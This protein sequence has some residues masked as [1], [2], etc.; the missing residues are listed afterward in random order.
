[1][2]KKKI[3][4]KKVQL[5]MVGIILFIVSV[6][7]SLCIGF[8]AELSAFSKNGI[9]DKNCPDAYL[10]STGTTDIKDFTSDEKVDIKDVYVL[11]GKTLSVPIQWKDKDISMYYDMM[12]DGSELEAWKYMSTT[13]GQAPNE[14]EIIISETLAIP[15]NINIGDTITV[16]YENPISFKVVGFYHTT[17]F[18]KAIGCAPI[19]GN[20]VDIEKLQSEK[21]AA[22]FALNF[23]NYNQDIHDIFML[24]PYCSVLRSRENVR[25]NLIEFS[26]VISTIGILAALLVFIV[27][28]LIMSYII[29]NDILKEL[30]TIGIYKGLGYNSKQIQNIYM[31]GY[32]IV[33]IVAVIIGSCCS[34][35]GIQKLC[36]MI[37][38]YVGGFRITCVSGI[39]LMTTIVVLSLVVYINLRVG[40]GKIKKISPLVAISMGSTMTDTVMKKSVIKNASTPFQ[41]AINEIFKYKKKNIM[42]IIAI[43]V[44]VYLSLLFTMI[45]YSSDRMLDNCNLW[46]CLPKNHA[47]ISGNISEELIDYLD[48]NSMIK[49]AVE[50]DFSYKMEATVVDYPEIDRSIRY[51]AYSTLDPSVLGMKITEGSAPIN[52]DEIIIGEGLQHQTGIKIGENI[53]L[54]INKKTVSYKVVGI[55]DTVADNSVKFMMTTDGLKESIPDYHYTKAYILL[56]NKKDYA[57]IKSDI[58]SKFNGVTVDTS[59]FAMENSVESIQQMLE[60]MSIVLVIAFLIFPLIN[61]TVMVIMNQKSKHKKYGVLKALGFT[62]SYII[63]QE[64]YKY[65]ILLT[66]GTSVAFIVHMLISARVMKMTLVDAF[67]NPVALMIVMLV[68]II[69]LILAVVYIISLPIKHISP[70]E[71]ME[72]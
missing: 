18:P 46:F 61:I 38:K 16:K 1:M 19:I 45:W 14:G 11:E 65:L 8:T 15:N 27:A 71:L 54:C 64:L 3:K 70:V 35:I 10:L 59:W 2:W 72:E 6:L 22:F 60:M 21:D 9:N 32:M 33:G 47:Y 42:A 66:V 49:S 28:L 53:N 56:N 44:S 52:N 55:F 48:N 39:V 40:L 23:E 69:A 5:C 24:S 43:M 34:I 30:H 17:C 26:S 36:N 50:G 31:I 68:L 25:E 29:K 13:S 7:L 4:Q 20:R 63:K 67:I 58:E 12:L 41:M 57:K 51:D 62:S 37:T